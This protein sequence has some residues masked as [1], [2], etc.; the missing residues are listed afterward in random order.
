MSKKDWVE[1]SDVMATL[2]ALQED[3]RKL[4]ARVTPPDGCSEVVIVPLQPRHGEY[5]KAKAASE[6]VTPEKYVEQLIRKDYNARPSLNPHTVSG[7]K[8]GRADAG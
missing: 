7:Q 8:I 3:Y 4:L 1:H 5:L 2:D 6:G